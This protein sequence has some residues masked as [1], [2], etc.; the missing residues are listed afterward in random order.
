MER[1]YYF[2]LVLTVFLLFTSCDTPLSKYAPKNDD[3]KSI[4]KLLKTHVDARNK[5]DINTIASSFHDNGVITYE[6]V[7]YT[8][9]QIAGS[10]PEMWSRYNIALFNT[11]INIHDKEATVNTVIK[12][13]IGIDRFRVPVSFTL[14]KEDDKWLI[15]RA[16]G[17]GSGK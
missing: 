7:K 6:S 3:E 14:A 5:G 13:K 15:L 1:S 9:S 11:E 2:S 10:D 12:A 8:K 4:L 17:Y 16:G